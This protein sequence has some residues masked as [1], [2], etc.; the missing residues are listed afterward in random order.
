MYPN[1]LSLHRTGA[2]FR[3][4]GYKKIKPAFGHPQPGD[5]YIIQRTGDHVYGHIAGYTGNG[6]ISDFRQKLCGI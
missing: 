5:I 1:I 6:W 2:Y 3:K 4:N